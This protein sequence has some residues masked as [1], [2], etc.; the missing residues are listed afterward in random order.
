V[1]RRASTTAGGLSDVGRARP[2]VPSAALRLL[3]AAT[4]AAS[5]SGGQE[6]ALRATLRLVCEFTGTPLGHVFLRWPGADLM[7]SSGIWHTDDAERFA[8]FIEQT[9]RHPLA[10]GEGLPG[11]ILA[12]GAPVGIADVIADGNFPRA[13]AARTCG[14]VAAFGAPIVGE[15]GI[16]GVM[17][18]F[19]AEALVW[20]EE[21]LDLLVQVG[22]Q[23][24]A[25]GDRARAQTLSEQRMEEAQRLA[26]VGSFSWDV[27]TDS[28]TWSPEL[29]RIYGLDRAKGPATVADYLA[30]VHEDDRARVEAAVQDAVSGG[31]AVEHEYRI[32]RADG[33]VRWLRSGFELVTETS[34]PPRLTGYCQDVTDRRRA[35]ERLRR[36]QDDLATH[37][38]VLERIARG[39]PLERTLVSLCAEV[40]ER[41]PGSRCSVLLADRSTGVLH[42]AAGPSLPAEVNAT[43]DGMPMAEGAGACGTAAFRKEAVEVED[44]FTDPLTA[45][46]REVAEAHELRS[47]WSHPLTDATGEVLGTFAVYW[48]TPHT[49]GPRERQTVQV[50]AGLAGLA[51]ERRRAEDALTN[52]A[53]VDS[54]TGLPNRAHFLDRVHALLAEPGVPRV[55]VMFLDVDRFKWIN[56]SLGHPA[57]DEV[58]VEVADRFAAVVGAGVMVARFGGDE[59]TVLLEDASPAAIDA[60]AG[61]IHHA[62]AAPF[63]LHGGEFYLTVSIG[64]AVSDGH[65][66]ASALVRDA[67]AAMYAAKEGGRSRHV[68]FDRQLRERAVARVT[69]EADL[70]RGIERDEFVVHFQPLVDLSDGEWTGF[71]ALARWRHPSG[72]PIGP[73]FFIP[74]AEE[75]GLIVPLGVQLLD[76]AIA[77]SAAW[78]SR[79]VRAHVGVNVSVVQLSD[80]TFAAEVER[81]LAAH[82]LPAE[83][84]FMEVTE[85]AVMEKIDTARATLDHLVGLGIPL[86]IDDFGT[87]YSSI[88]RLGELPVIG[89]K[90]DRAFTARLGSHD[91]ASRIISAII[92]LAHALDMLVV[93]EGVETEAAVAEL[94]A[95]GCNFGQGYHFGRP[96]SAEDLPRPYGSVGV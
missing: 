24:G 51:I 36:A 35:E 53:V 49:P 30:Y 23:L 62:F 60:I 15:R 28:V 19:A 48:R 26:G 3:D 95:L 83:L 86:L 81:L 43:L 41:F 46:Y 89:V 33:E 4:T 12:T 5:A 93:A 94:A 78:L 55:A 27:G 56:D 22:H 6:E 69:M 57:G 2:G 77:Q 70:R 25:A 50:C 47:V 44:A 87:G 45:P 21:L 20:D 11:R 31:H 38:A 74:V 91:S 65:N 37:A 40:E 63:E 88:A 29:Y 58:L 64:I 17:E 80:P 13:E 76:K 8:P 39:E 10:E 16:E 42:T 14:I 68:V 67:D 85:S 34:G 84:L 59:F 71:E 73:D 1:A 18:F 96:V 52:A 90:I 54:L 72:Q 9:Q 61:A 82:E 7:V 75:T 32:R 92:E 66:D 79:G